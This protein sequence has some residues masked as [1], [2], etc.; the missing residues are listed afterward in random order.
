MQVL[1]MHYLKK[2]D[3]LNLFNCRNYNNFMQ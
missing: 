3:I 2:I 1:D